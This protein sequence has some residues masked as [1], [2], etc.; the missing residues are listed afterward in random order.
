MTD[1][2]RRAINKLTTK[3]TTGKRA[4]GTALLDSQKQI[5][6]GM[7]LVDDC[8]IA[9]AKKALEISNNEVA[10]AVAL[11][12][13]NNTLLHFPIYI[14]GIRN[15]AGHYVSLFLRSKFCVVIIFILFSFQTEISKL[16]TT[17]SFYLFS[18][19]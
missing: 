13:K 2:L 7:S 8:T 3:K 19:I 12:S 5:A 4:P 1:C 18:W 9:A 15:A 11:L 14:S 10:A 16:L 17:Y 6:A